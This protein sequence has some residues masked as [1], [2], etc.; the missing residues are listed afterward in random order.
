MAI[1]LAVSRAVTRIH[2]LERALH[3]HGP[4]YVRADSFMVPAIRDV[5]DQA[6]IFR[7]RAPSGGFAELWLRDEFVIAIGTVTAESLSF[8][9]TLAG[10]LAA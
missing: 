10:E 4:W 2:A 3:E 1:E 8:E 9:L 7:F 5:T 6:V